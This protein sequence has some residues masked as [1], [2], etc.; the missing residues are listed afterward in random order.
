MVNACSPELMSSTVLATGSVTGQLLPGNGGAAA[1]IARTTGGRLG[2]D[3]TT[4][5]EGFDPLGDGY[6]ARIIGQLT[7]EVTVSKMPIPAPTTLARPVAISFTIKDGDN[8]YIVSRRGS[9]RDADTGRE[10]ERDT[11]IKRAKQA[12]RCRHGRAS[13]WQRCYRRCRHERSAIWK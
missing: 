11:V 6:S 3:S 4:S 12:R 1:Q 10:A 7:V 8:E 5:G 9:D 13:R 2:G